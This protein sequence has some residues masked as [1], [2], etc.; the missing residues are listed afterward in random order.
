M[1]FGKS[2]ER[3]WPQEATPYHR[4]MIYRVQF[5]IAFNDPNVGF[6]EISITDESLFQKIR[7]HYPGTSINPRWFIAELPYEEAVETK[8][9]VAIYNKTG[10]RPATQSYYTPPSPQTFFQVSVIRIPSEE[11]MNESSLLLLLPPEGILATYDFNDVPKDGSFVVK[12]AGRRS[13]LLFGGAEYQ[14]WCML[15]KDELKNALL[16]SGLSGIQFRP[17][18]ISAGK[19]I[20]L[21]QLWGDAE[22]P[23]PT[24]NRCKVTSTERMPS[25]DDEGYSPAIPRYEKH[26]LSLFT[27]PDVVRMQESCLGYAPCMLVS[28][29]FRQVADKLAPGQFRYGIVAI[30]EG[31]ELKNR[32]TI[33]EF[34]PPN[35]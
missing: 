21:W 17:V 35:A 18:K 28:Q 13:K 7:R 22:M 9:F 12:G 26:R 6:S 8:L 3:L 34:A 27:M 29:R 15:F 19:Q 31:E 4:V 16:Q 24:M 2:L 33:S 14:T 30:G 25:F 10:R 23:S 11:E 5:C 1:I 32:Y 20:P